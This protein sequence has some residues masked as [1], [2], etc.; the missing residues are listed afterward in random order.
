MYIY[1]IYMHMYICIY[2]YMILLRD[3]A[4]RLQ[5]FFVILF[6]IIQ[7]DFGGNVTVITLA[8]AMDSEIDQIWDRF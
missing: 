8:V 5:I 7:R 6:V 4:K 2:I 3:F 1:I